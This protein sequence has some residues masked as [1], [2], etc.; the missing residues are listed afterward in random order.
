MWKF[1]QNTM[2]NGY[3]NNSDNRMKESS[4]MH[5]L[6]KMNKQYLWTERKS[7]I[8]WK[9]MKVQILSLDWKNTKYAADEMNFHEMFG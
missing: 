6:L 5:M 1:L 7:L 2:G 8:I 9:Q 3:A 4:E